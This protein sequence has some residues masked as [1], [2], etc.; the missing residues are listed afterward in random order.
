MSTRAR[1][2]DGNI[3]RREVKHAAWDPH[4]PPLAVSGTNTCIWSH[5]SRIRSTVLWLSVILNDLL[6]H[7][8]TDSATHLAML[9]TQLKVNDCVQ[10]MNQW[11]LKD[12]KMTNWKEMT[13]LFAALVEANS[14]N[15]QKMQAWLWHMTVT[16]HRLWKTSQRNAVCARNTTNQEYESKRRH[17]SQRV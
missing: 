15:K 11:L 17:S 7:W 2:R 6:A 9:L 5:Y 8:Q 3:I 10:P 16:S 12:S 1:Q 14:V 4:L 13:H